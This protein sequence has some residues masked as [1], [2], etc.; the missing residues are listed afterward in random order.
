MSSSA[1]KTKRTALSS[2]AKISK[3]RLTSDFSSVLKEILEFEVS[4]KAQEVAVVDKKWYDSMVKWGK[5]ETNRKPEKPN[6]T[7][8]N[9]L[10]PKYKIDFEVIPKKSWEAVAKTFGSTDK[11]LKFILLS[12]ETREPTLLIKDYQLSINVPEK[13]KPIKKHV[14]KDWALGGIKK[15]LC[16]TLN[17]N[18]E[19]FAFFY[20]NEMIDENKKACDFGTS[21]TLQ[22]Q[23]KNFI[24]T[25]TSTTTP[26]LTSSAINQTRKSPS[27]VIDAHD[28]KTNSTSSRLPN[29]NDSPSKSIKRPVSTFVD[30]DEEPQYTKA[31]NT[32]EAAPKRSLVSTS[33]RSTYPCPCGFR[34]LGNTCFFNSAVQCLIRIEPLTKYVLSNDFE[35]DI[36][37]KNPEGSHGRIASAYKE[38]LTDL[39]RA[40]SIYDPGSLRK[41]FISKY[42]SFAN[43]AQHDSSELLGC[44]LD[45]LHEDLNQAYEARGR[46]PQVPQTKEMGTWEIHCARNSSKILD[47]FHGTFYSSI[48]CPSCGFVESIYDPFSFLSAPIP[49]KSFGSVN[50][51]DCLESFSQ[52]DVLD[53]NNKWKCPKCKEMVCATK[54]MGLNRCAPI[55]IIAFKRFSGTGYYATK[56]NT[57]VDYPDVLDTNRFTEKQSGKYKLIGTVFHSGTLS[58]GHYTSAAIDPAS[59]NWYNFNDSTCTPISSSG[60]HKGSAYIVIYQKV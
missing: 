42:H 39:L 11:N 38:L 49:Q 12:P 47:L 59:G 30:D 4:D 25:S 7:L 32:Y 18:P 29:I 35:N 44:M 57:N 27:K 54:R 52:V 20:G 50:L 51:Y 22:L 26:K 17:I 31:P 3:S 28:Y 55:L 23:K 16:S 1:T 9:N 45:G 19:E 56:V 43:Y 6:N 13:I 36:N 2:T 53:K 10:S 46:N 24:I 37:T 15:Q 58:G 8:K 41:A 33:G 14:S 48:E 5:N 21:K 60:A 40:P 34:N